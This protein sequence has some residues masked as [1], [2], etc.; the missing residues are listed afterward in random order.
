MIPDAVRNQNN[1]YYYG[2]V[3]PDDATL[4]QEILAAG[5]D[6][7]AQTPLTT[8]PATTQT[9]KPPATGD[10]FLDR[11]LLWGAAALGGVV[12]AV[13]VAMPIAMKK[14]KERLNNS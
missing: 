3:I 9:T 8:A 4:W 6:T 10:V 2:D 1:P 14:R 11:P 7:N 12:I 5:G 13:A